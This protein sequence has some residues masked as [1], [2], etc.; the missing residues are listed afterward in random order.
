MFY[1]FWHAYYQIKM[2]Q[3]SNKNGFII[4]F[5]FTACLEVSLGNYSNYS[6]WVTKD[7]C[8]ILKAL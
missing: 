6:I 3:D 8:L 4:L 7:V 1:D 5:Y 2:Q